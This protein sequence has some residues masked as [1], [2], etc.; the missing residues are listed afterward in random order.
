MNAYDDYSVE[1][2]VR[3]LKRN[4]FMSKDGLVEFLWLLSYEVYDEICKRKKEFDPNIRD[5]LT[6]FVPFPGARDY[7]DAEWEADQLRI[8][9]TRERNIREFRKSFVP[10]PRPRQEIDDMFDTFVQQLTD[11]KKRLEDAI[12]SATKRRGYVPPNR[13]TP[14]MYD[15]DPLVS[16]A[17]NNLA[18]KEN[19]FEL[20]KKTVESLDKVWTE[21]KFIDALGENA[22]RFYAA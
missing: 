6:D 17:R 5:L 7:T 2:A 13:R 10:P 1:D 20:I 22:K 12:A 18:D 16:T 19:E 4:W 3:V 14:G 11:L 21:E 15:N 9:E 8:A